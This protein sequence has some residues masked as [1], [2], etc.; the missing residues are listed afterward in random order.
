VH[1]VLNRAAAAR[2]DIDALVDE[3]LAAFEPLSLWCL[4]EDPRVTR[5]GWRGTLVGSG[6]F[7]RAVHD[8]ACRVAGTHGPRSYDSD[9]ERAAS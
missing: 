6:P 4:P 7:T 1:L 3:L 5:S 9:V 8:V 2:R